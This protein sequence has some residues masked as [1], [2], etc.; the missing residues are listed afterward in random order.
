MTVPP[1][2]TPMAFARGLADAGLG[3]ED[4]LVRLRLEGLSLP[5]QTVKILVHGKKHT[6][7]QAS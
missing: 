5:Y 7:R 1:A 2:P 4:I 6:V 3:V